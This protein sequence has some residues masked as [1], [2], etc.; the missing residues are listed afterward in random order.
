MNY[1]CTFNEQRLEFLMAIKDKSIFLI[2]FIKQ[3]ET[4]P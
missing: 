2:H 1:D 3:T 4:K